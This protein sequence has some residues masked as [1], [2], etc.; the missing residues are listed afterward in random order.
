MV[1]GNGNEATSDGVNSGSL[2]VTSTIRVATIVHPTV[3]HSVLPTILPVSMNLE[4][5][6]T[7]FGTF[8]CYLHFER[9][10][11]NVS[12]P[13]VRST[14]KSILRLELTTPVTLQN[15]SILIFSRG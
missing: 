7:I 15:R 9:S 13:D 14:L 8:K 11:W 1:S 5:I 2:P 3:S 12:L 10:I 6:T 4:E